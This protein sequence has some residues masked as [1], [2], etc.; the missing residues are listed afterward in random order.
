MNT[1][2]YQIEQIKSIVNG[3]LIK[4]S[5][6]FYT[7]HTLLT[8]SRSV[9]NAENSIFIALKTQRNN[10]HKYLKD[11]YEKGVRNFI[12]SENIDDDLLPE[13]NIILV[14]DTL[15]ALQSLSTY[16][17]SRF[18]IPII[19]ITGSNGKTIVKEWLYQ[20]LH[21]DFNIIRSPKSYNSQI[22]VPLSV[23]QMNDKHTLGIFEAGL[24]QTGEM[25]KLQPIIN[26]TIGIFTNIG[27]AHDE[28]FSSRQQKATEKL[29]LFA[30]ADILIY[31]ADNKEI[32]KAIASSKLSENLVFFTWGQSENADIHITSIEKQLSKST[33]KGIYKSKNIE[34]SIPFS[35]EASI[36]NAMHCWATLLMLNYENSVI[37]EKMLGLQPLAMRL[38]IKQ[39]IN[40]CTIINDSY[41]ND[42]D[43]LA[44]AL[45]FLN[46]QNQHGKRIVILSDILQS[47]INKEK[48]YA[49]VNTLLKNKN[50]DKIIGIGSEIEACASAFSI[51]KTFFG[52][53]H[54]FLNHLNTK[55]FVNTT[56]LLKGARIFG[57]ELISEALQQ[58]THETVLEVNLNGLIHN[59]NYYRSQ[60]PPH[61]K[62]MAMVKAFSYGSGS[63]EIANALQF[64]HVDYL[65]VAYADEGVELRKNGI[66]LPIMVM[67]PEIDS[68]HAM[69]TYNLEPEIYSFRVLDM[70]VR[71]LQELEI[72]NQVGIHIKI[73][74]GM[75]R[76]GFDINQIDDLINHLKEAYEV[77]AVKSV[78]SHLA[79]ADDP[80]KD[81][82][83]HHQINLFKT[84]SHK[85]LNSFNYPILRHICNSAAINRFPEAAFDMV[86]LG[87]GLYGIA[88][89]KE[90]LHKLENVSTLR[91]TI[92]QIKTIEKNES[93]GY[94]RM[95]RA[96]QTS[97]IAVV[98][99]GYA[100]G[101]NR[102][103][104]NGIGKFMVKGNIVPTVGN[105]CMDMTMIDVTGIGAQEG[106]EVLI[107]G[108][109]LPI[110]QLS[111]A[112]GT[113][114]YEILTGISQ[115]VKRIY[116]Q[117]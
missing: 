79:T 110:T 33:I 16:H 112:I 3:S 41:S 115:R 24:S 99:I 37:A 56:I 93:V 46:H 83:T 61:V 54:A 94:G 68:I 98:P 34:I 87:I 117:E 111:D 10:G 88:P 69:I 81:D 76:L 101:I 19:G 45:D 108:K 51:P 9:T 67:N 77:L 2:E 113:I 74:T 14:K 15:A 44:I 103:L 49:Q 114:P 40:N 75:R 17:R 43:S 20:L 64:H 65:T 91:T 50:I 47:G 62:T 73:D 8:D 70:F 26:P 27:H 66:S 116:Y 35:D 7:I 78:F 55:D 52:S 84:A 80:S 11:V 48:L 39:G 6:D 23:W 109:E 29:K 63:F 5:A 1:T 38:E 53:T 95:F 90:A 58:K 57:F 85:I 42:I 82:F 12:V 30:N 97:Q 86:R 104:G 105:V 71:Y 100:D 4:K 96:K 25:E 72:K 102:K 21:N 36:E 107:F 13:S 92:S 28:N 106:D 59:L 32:G 18:N 31:A 89:V 60:I 22:G